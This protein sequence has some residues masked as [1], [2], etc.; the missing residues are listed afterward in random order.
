[1]KM[2]N[3]YSHLQTNIFRYPLFDNNFVVTQHKKCYPFNHFKLKYNCCYFDKIKIINIYCN[4]HEGRLD[5][6]DDLI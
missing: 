6:K 5:T 3:R 4:V 1:M 2:T